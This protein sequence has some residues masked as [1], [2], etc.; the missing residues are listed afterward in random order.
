MKYLILALTVCFQLQNARADNAPVYAAQLNRFQ[1]DQNLP[2]TNIEDGEVLVDLHENTVRVTL[3][4]EW[5]CP[6][7]AFCRAVVPAP[8]TIELPI[9]ERTKNPCGTAIIRAFS[10][11]DATDTVSERLEV[12]DNTRNTCPHI[13]PVPPTEI[14]YETIRQIDDDDPAERTVSK[15]EGDRL[16]R[17]R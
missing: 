1:I 14:V 13:L 16:K 11:N 4:P 7:G 9:F 10:R 5:Y 15:F 17:I 2:L 8:V 3:Q 12:R 6:P